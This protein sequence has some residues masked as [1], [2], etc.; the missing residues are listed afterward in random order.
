[1]PS[2][3]NG[4]DGG[5]GGGGGVVITN[6][7]NGVDG[8]AGSGGY[9][10]GGGGGAGTGAFDVSYNVIG[11]AGGVGGGG[12]G[13]G[14]NQSG[15]TPADG[16]NSLGG[17]GGGGGGPSNGLTASGGADIGNL[18]G[19]SGGF[20]ANVFGF[21][22][23]GGGGGGG[24]G[25][26]GAIF[27]DSNLNFTLQAIPGIPTI[28]NTFNTTT[29][30]GTGGIGG[31][32]GTNGL[33]GSALGN[34]IFLRAGSSL[35][36]VANDAADLLTLGD[37]VAFIDDSS[38][39]TG[40]T[41][42]F[43]RGDGTVVYNG[44]TDY[45]GTILINNAN[46]KVNGLI[47]SA[48][49]FVCRN[50]SFSSQRGMLSGIGAV[51]GSVFVNSGTISPDN[52]ETLLLGSLS[53][54]P[55][56]LDNDTLGSL[57]HIEIGPNNISSGIVV[58]GSAELAGA[59]EID[60]NPNAQVGSYILLTSAGIT[61]TFDSVI[62]PGATPNYQLSYL[63]SE[64]PTF[65]QLDFLGSVILPPSN[66]QGNQ[67]KNDFGLVYELYNQLIWTSSPSSETAG[68]FIYRDGKRIATVDAST[69][70][71]KDHRRKKG[72]SYAYA[73]TAFNSEGNESSPINIVVRP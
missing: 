40:G 68:Y 6:S 20:G 65:V 34:S 23:G 45:Q 18:G 55:A 48:S 4:G 29:V 15:T 31:P 10:G 69:H 25:L 72:I 27:V 50:T 22:S 46:L 11:G 7:S 24:S 3:G 17:G 61:G 2:G 26:G 44:S 70:T 9:G 5:G 41:N 38:F 60:I 71:Y 53:L 39:G 66:F 35:T 51:T 67:K 33:N 47:D 49:I 42:I 32:G 52:G 54:N 64:N 16:G 1:V 56:D 12:G 59:L 8:Q 73:I 21:G 30:A 63:P 13:G 62:F 58:N 28:F 43:V 37:Q 14:V 57:V 19:G 36:F